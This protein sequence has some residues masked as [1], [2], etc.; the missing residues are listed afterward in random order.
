MS[1]TK[2]LLPILLFPLMLRTLLVTSES[3]HSQNCYSLSRSPHSATLETKR[4]SNSLYSK[5]RLVR[6]RRGR[7]GRHGLQRV[8]PPPAA[9]TAAPPRASAFLVFDIIK[10]FGRLSDQELL[11]HVISHNNDFIKLSQNEKRKKW[12][13]LFL[14]NKDGVNFEAFKNF[15]RQAPFEWPLTINSG[16]IKNQGSISI[17][18]SPIVYVESCR[19]ISE[20]L[21]GK[22]KNKGASAGTATGA[23]INLKII[24]DYVSEQPISNDAIQCVFSSFSDLPELTKDQFISKIHEWAPSDGIIDWY[25]FVYN[26]KEE[27]SDNIKRFFD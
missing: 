10:I 8:P 22:N 15:L 1:A 3:K 13:K 9:A 27:P 23:K 24:N 5:K 4:K 6:L 18:V 2:L 14:P 25:T 19:K 16:Q 26:L 7:Q 21:K 20:F 12:E 11:G 17:P